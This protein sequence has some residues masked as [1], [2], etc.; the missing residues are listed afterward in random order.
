MASSA[1]NERRQQ[2][3][4]GVAWI[5]EFHPQVNSLRDVDSEMLNQYVASK[6]KLVNT[7]CKYV[8]EEIQRLL[9][10][11]DDLQHGN[12]K[13]LREKMFAT[14]KGL[15]EEYEV[16]CKE[17]NVLIACVTNH[18]AVAGARMMGDGFGGGTIN[19]IEEN[20]LDE[21]ITTVCK[22]YQQVI[23]MQLTPIIVNIENGTSIITD[24][25]FETDSSKF[26]QSF[27]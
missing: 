26:N 9:N 16:S 24:K 22:K 8:V 25:K 15:S 1:Y 2:C 7:R 12:I 17:L 10:A 20:K 19:I 27:K 11:C 3:E 18:A 14:H 5:K 6:D 4:Q 23:N 13:A 21:V